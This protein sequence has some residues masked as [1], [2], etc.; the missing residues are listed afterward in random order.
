MQGVWVRSLVREL[1]S[2]M[3]HDKK[4]KKETNK[5]TKK[6]TKQKQYCNKFNKDFKK[7][8]IK[9]TQ[10]ILM[11]FGGIR[12]QEGYCYCSS[13]FRSS[14]V[15][16]ITEKGEN[17]SFAVISL[18]NWI[19]MIVEYH[20]GIILKVIELCFAPHG[21]TEWSLFFGFI[22]VFFFFKFLLCIGV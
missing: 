16:S 10:K 3:P 15:P 18:I 17:N 4:K 21:K 12:G 2:R 5:Q 11:T 1:R 6:P 20:E 22:L 8:H 9:K 13:D 7:V 14:S 19:V